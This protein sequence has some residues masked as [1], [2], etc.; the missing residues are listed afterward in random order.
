MV[1]WIICFMDG[2]KKWMVGWMDGW[3]DENNRW[4]VGWMD[5]YKII[6]IKIDEW[7]EV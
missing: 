4:M 6:S 1:R 5:E 3:K 7:Q 2:Q